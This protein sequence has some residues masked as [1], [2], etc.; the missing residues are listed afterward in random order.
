MI[1][2]CCPPPPNPLPGGGIYGR[3]AGTPRAQ[4]RQAKH[5]VI[6]EKLK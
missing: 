3:Y 1:L 6:W 4:C 5:P 2:V